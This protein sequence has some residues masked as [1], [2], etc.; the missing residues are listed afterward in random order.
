MAILD[1]DVLLENLQDLEEVPEKVR[2]P[3]EGK[4]EEVLTDSLLEISEKILY[5]DQKSTELII[6]TGW[7]EAVS[8]HHI[9]KSQFAKPILINRLG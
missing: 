6:G 7:E 8:R 5:D 3:C 9:S 4:W 1:N 2:S